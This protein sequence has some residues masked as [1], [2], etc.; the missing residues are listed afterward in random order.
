MSEKPPMLPR[1][2][3]VDLG[4]I[5][6]PTLLDSQERDWTGI[7]VQYHRQPAWEMPEFSDSQHILIV[8]GWSKSMIS[9]VS[10]VSPK[11]ELLRSLVV[12]EA[13]FLNGMTHLNGDC[14]LMADSYRGA[15]WAIDSVSGQVQ[16]RLEHPLL[17]RQNTENLTPGINGIHVYQNVLYASNTEAKEIIH[18]PLSDNSP[19]TPEIW[20][21]GD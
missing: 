5:P 1:S 10:W 9:T 19:R 13:M 4:L 2:Q 12:P 3:A 8:G 17:T 20:L 16:I 7:I 18:I 15:I 21:K 14:Y 6:L 11:G